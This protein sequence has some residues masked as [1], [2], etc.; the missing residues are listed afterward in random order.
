VPT[1]KQNGPA[2]MDGNNVVL[3]EEMWKASQN[4]DRHTT[5]TYLYRQMVGLMQRLVEPRG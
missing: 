1:V 4:R 2:T 5:A 3:E